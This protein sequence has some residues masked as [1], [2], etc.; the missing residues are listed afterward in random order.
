VSTNSSRALMAC[1]TYLSANGRPPAGTSQLNPICLA[2]P[3]GFN[4]VDANLSARV[5]KKC[6][7]CDAA[8]YASRSA[9][10]GVEYSS[11]HTGHMVG[12]VVTRL[13]LGPRVSPQQVP[14]VSL[15]IQEYRNSAVRLLAG[16]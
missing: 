14:T 1:S 4:G 12:L 6:Q 3:Q 9:V 15:A 10:S 7:G 8:D 16:R 2:K 11:R 5:G 13:G